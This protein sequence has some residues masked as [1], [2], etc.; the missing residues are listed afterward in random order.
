[1]LALATL[2]APRAEVVRGGTA[3]LVA[4]RE[5]VPGD[6]VL[7]ASGSRVPADLRLLAINDLEVDESALTGESLAVRKKSREL[8][9]SAGAGRP[10]EHGVRRHRRHA[11]ARRGRRGRAPGRRPS[12]V[13][14]RP[15]CR[16][17]R[18]SPPRSSGGST[19]FGRRVGVLIAAL[20][21]LVVLIGWL[22]GMS[23]RR[24]SSPRWRWRSRRSPRA[25]RWC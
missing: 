5:L 21:V 23:P 25:C 20:S 11:R 7:L 1:M 24:S 12:W 22:R 6:R 3:A 4:S 8:R 19:R 16:S 15:R 10:D 13:G 14:S 18:R 17:R 9:A 2:A